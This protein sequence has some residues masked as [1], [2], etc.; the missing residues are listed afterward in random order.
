MSEFIRPLLDRLSNR[1]I[2]LVE[3]SARTERRVYNLPARGPNEGQRQVLVFSRFV[4]GDNRTRFQW[5]SDASRVLDQEPILTYYPRAQSNGIYRIQTV[6][7]TACK[8]KPAMYSGSS[9]GVKAGQCLTRVPAWCDEDQRFH[10][11]LSM[12][13]D[14][15]HLNGNGSGLQGRLL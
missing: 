7:P 5:H 8:H 15:Y 12:F 13:R 3:Q 6:R 9:I 11:K 2:R 1:D 14:M 4:K 10:I